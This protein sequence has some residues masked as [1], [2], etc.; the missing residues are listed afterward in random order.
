MKTAIYVLTLLA[1]LLVLG[2]SGPI[3]KC[4]SECMT[5]SREGLGDCPKI[6]EAKRQSL[7]KQHCEMMHSD[8][9][10]LRSIAKNT[11]YI[12]RWGCK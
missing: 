1:S 5:D 11:A 7:C 10:N 6:P 12:M 2:C 9:E 8:S 4:T 3:G